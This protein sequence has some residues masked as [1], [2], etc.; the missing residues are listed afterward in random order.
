GLAKLLVH[1][2]SAGSLE[3]AIRTALRIAA[4]DPLQESVHRTLMRLYVRSGRRGA[5]LRQYQICVGVLLRELGIEPEPET[6]QLYRDI[7]QRSAVDH[8][9]AYVPEVAADGN[10]Y[11]DGAIATATRGTSDAPQHETALI[12]RERELTILQGALAAAEMQRGQ[13]L[14]VVGEAGVAQTT[15]ITALAPPAAPRATS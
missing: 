13:V 6:R 14:I 4:L 7:L 9:A 11:R 8:D 1:Q 5:A 12:G 10:V 3:G 15:L 2:R